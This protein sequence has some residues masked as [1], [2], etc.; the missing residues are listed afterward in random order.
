MHSENPS[1]TEIL[2]RWQT[3]AEFVADM[4]VPYERAKKWRARGRAIPPKY[5]PRLIDMAEQRFG[6]VLTPRQL[7]LAAGAEI[8]EQSQSADGEGA[9]S[10]QKE[11][12]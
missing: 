12:A 2:S 4:N 3:L 1:F 11:T 9:D 5:W 8:D 6:L 7:M 10:A